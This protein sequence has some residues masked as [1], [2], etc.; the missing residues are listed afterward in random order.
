MTRHGDILLD[1]IV[2]EMTNEAM[3]CMYSCPLQVTQQPQQYT[4]VLN[5][6]IN[7]SKYTLC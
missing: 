1:V 2:H 5:I 7:L 3:M 4:D 6:N